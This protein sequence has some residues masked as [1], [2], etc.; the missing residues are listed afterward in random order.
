MN[1]PFSGVRR[2]GS[3]K[4]RS[5]KVLIFGSKL[6]DY[7]YIYMP[8]IFF[9]ER[10][11]YYKDFAF[12]LLVRNELYFCFGR[13]HE[14]HECT[15]QVIITLNFRILIRRLIFNLGGT[16]SKFFLNQKFQIRYNITIST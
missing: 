3:I 9:T 6:T 13:S 1:N 12:I 16:K 15:N 5:P 14:S 11:F 2:Y 7:I 8:F 10:R 4:S